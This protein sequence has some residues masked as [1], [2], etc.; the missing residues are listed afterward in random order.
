MMVSKPT[1]KDVA[2]IAGV[3]VNTVSSILNN[4]ADSWASEKTR[5]RVLAAAKELGYQPNQ[6][7]RGLRL[8]CYHTIGGLFSD[9]TNPFY[10][11]LVR[12]LQQAF[13]S[14]GYTMIVEEGELDAARE[15]KCLTS[16]VSRQIDGL[17]C[18][19]LDYQSNG[20]TLEEI[21]RQLPV[22]VIG[23]T[24]ALKS[25]DTIE[26]DF[27]SSLF[28][29]VDYLKSLGHERIAYVNA[30][31]PEKDLGKRT[32]HFYEALKKYRMPV[33]E[34][35]YLNCGFYALSHVR[36]TAREWLK[37][38][39]AA[40]RPTALICLNDIT[41]IGVS[42]G[43]LDLDLGIPR[44]ISLVGID[45]V[46][47]AAYLPF[48]LTTIAQPAEELAAFCAERLIERIAGRN[49]L[50]PVHR[51][52]PTRLIIRESTGPAPAGVLG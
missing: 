5:A 27:Q 48:P 47:I 45:N 21:N 39:P 14:R 3:A 20:P 28:H 22:I 10:A 17:V 49:P 50:E 30:Y 25:M 35:S 52:L 1:L 11:L 32:D 13:D 9:L 8:R 33:T 31:P 41:A 34:D 6:A 36:E 46:E 29:A 40:R 23:G 37:A 19:G 2:K 4:R 38:F 44:D 24:E 51:I 7:A 43:I 15:A 16:L 12:F 42:R 26:S 18:S